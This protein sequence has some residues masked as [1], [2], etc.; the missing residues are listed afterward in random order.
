MAD[1][2]I[3]DLPLVSSIDAGDV[4]VID[5]GSTR[6]IEVM[7][8]PITTAM[9]TSLDGKLAPSDIGVS[10][11]AHSGN[12]DAFA[13]K[14]APAGVVVGTTDPQTLTNKTLTT[15]AISSPT[16]LVK[17][18]VGLGNVDNTSDAAKNA[19]SATL[20]NK[21]LTSP[22]INSPTGIVKGDVGLGNVDN[23]SDA[24]KN[25]ATA[26]LANK[27][28]AS[29]V[30]TGTA[31]GNGTIPG[32]ML[33]NTSVTPGSYTNTNLTVDAQGRITAASNGSGGGSLPARYI[34]FYN[35]QN[36]NGTYN[37]GFA[38]G[39]S[40][41][42]F[43]G[44]TVITPVSSYV[45]NPDDKQGKQSPCPILVNDKVYVYYEGYNGTTKQI[46]LEIYSTDGSLYLK[47][48]QPVLLI[49]QV[50]GASMVARPSVLYEPSDVAAP[51]KMAFTVATSGLNGI[52]IYGATSLD[53]VNWTV[54]GQFLTI[55]TGWEATGLATDG[56][57]IKD[58]ST[59][60]IFYSGISAAAIVQSGEMHNNT[61]TTSGWTK[62]SGNPLFVVSGGYDITVTA[63]INAGTRT[64]TVANSALF[65]V[66]AVVAV[67]TVGGTSFTLNQIA[68][69]PNGTTLTMLYNWVGTIP[70]A[71][72]PRVSQFTSHSVSWTEVWFDSA[73][74][75]WKAIGTAF[76]F[77]PGILGETIC[78]GESPNL[79]TPFT[80]LYDQWP[81]PLNPNLLTFDQTSAENLK[82]I[83]LQ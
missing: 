12:L 42:A 5:G 76:Q 43:G 78:Y 71:S 36:G 17:S 33:V 25:A 7:D 41:L 11:Q 77:T 58:G 49:G 20:T 19:A 24:T 54:L 67:Y 9:Q 14:V 62:S 60:R 45:G 2:R 55:S 13:G 65:N 75:K 51:F 66:G 16:G 28:L 59:Y 23:T 22:V 64:V 34:G 74:N 35:G 52:S 37:L 8:L 18:D 26:T 27:T 56:R 73:A 72:N 39:S 81:L 69:I 80:I 32:A 6:S 68:A 70:L 31:S 53:G 57:L 21:T 44:R 83:K 1:K 30:I 40:Y 48:I 79:T 46:F 4:L 61:F 38:S 82:F 47:P 63:Q 29:P 10:V 3:S 15:P 50:A